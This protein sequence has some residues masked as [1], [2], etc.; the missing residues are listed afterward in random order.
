[1]KI[2]NQRPHTHTPPPH[3]T[4]KTLTKSSIADDQMVMTQLNILM[5]VGMAMMDVEE[6]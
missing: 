3:T 1:M 4:K 2:R 5:P 6:L